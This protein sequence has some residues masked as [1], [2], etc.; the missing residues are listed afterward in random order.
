[1]AGEIFFRRATA[2][3]RARTSII[4]GPRLIEKRIY[5][6]AVWQR[7]RITVLKHHTILS[8]RVKALGL[9]FEHCM[10]SVSLRLMWKF[11]VILLC[12]CVNCLLVCFSPG[13][14]LVVLLAHS[15]WSYHGKV[16]FH[17]CTFSSKFQ[18]HEDNYEIMTDFEGCYRGI[19]FHFFFLVFEICS[20][21]I[22]RMIWSKTKLKHWNDY[23]VTVKRKWNCAAQRVH[24]RNRL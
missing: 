1:M 10:W 21:C 22:I 19:F 16:I 18:I 6:A 5:R 8:V 17:S 13:L 24:C 12:E 11:C 23:Q 9:Y 2:R 15:L 14:L 20:V 3:Y 4:L 7:L